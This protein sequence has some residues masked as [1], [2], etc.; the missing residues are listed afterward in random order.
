MNTCALPIDTALIIA[1]HRNANGANV[2][3]LNNALQRYEL[4]CYA[5]QAEIKQRAEHELYEL[6]TRAA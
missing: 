3:R 2:H 5:G 6:L 1:V 4:A